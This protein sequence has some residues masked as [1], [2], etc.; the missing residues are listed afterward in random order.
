MLYLK[1]SYRK[2]PAFYIADKDGEHK[3][4]LRNITSEN[5]FTYRN[6]MIAY[7]SY[8][9]S[10][11]WSLVNYSNITLL[12]IATGQEKQITKE[13]KYFTPDISPDGSQLIAVSYTDSL[14]SELHLLT[15]EGAVVKKIAAPGGALF[16]HPRFITNEEFVVAV[17]QAN[18]TMSLEKGSLVTLKM[19]PIISP[20]AATLGYPSV[21]GNKLYYVSSQ[22]GNDEIY[23]ADLSGKLPLQKARQL[24]FDQA[25]N[26]FPSVR[27]DSITWAHFTSNGY[28]I[29]TK[30]LK[31]IKGIEI[32]GSEFEKRFLPFKI[33]LQ[34]AAP[35]MLAS[36]SRQFVESPYKKSSGLFNFHSWRPNYT[37][38]EITYS[39]YSDNYLNTFSNEIFYR[40]NI[41]E[42]SHA[43][44]FNSYYGGFFPVINAGVAYTFDRTIKTTSL[45]Y[46]LDQFEARVGY[47]IPLTFTGGKT[48]KLFNFGSNFVYSSLMP[49]GI[50]KHYYKAERQPISII[51][52]HSHSSY[53]E[54][55]NIFIQ[56]LVIILAYS[57]VT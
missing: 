31:A 3:I 22:S 38:P 1:T 24:T 7:T 32:S 50:L 11:R 10:A 34:D 23:E 27:N 57:I 9:T 13:A 21:I 54:Q 56:S 55:F 19:E 14:Q 25:G 33:G 5:W 48:Y 12:D 42:T 26:Y 37:D 16:V 8:N 28:R 30:D 41:D 17:R 2:L 39:L 51:T 36:T 20:V 43:V 49:T 40:Y 35:N 6:G 4:K 47:N 52:C 53:L 18:S 29:Q 45:T 46:T 44:G 15:T